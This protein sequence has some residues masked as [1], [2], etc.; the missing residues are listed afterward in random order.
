MRQIVKHYYKLAGVRGERKTT[1]SL[2]HTAI[3]SAVRHGAPVQKVRAMARHANIETTM[4]YY[5]EIDRIENPAEAFISY[6][7]AGT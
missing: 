7:E 4:I 6:E 1:H 3:S 2:R 5:H